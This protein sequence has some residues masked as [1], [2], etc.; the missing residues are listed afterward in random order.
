MGG[1]GASP[2][3]PLHAGTSIWFALTQA[4]T[5][6]ALSKERARLSFVSGG[7][8]CVFTYSPI[9]WGS[10][11]LSASS[12]AMS[13]EKRGWDTDVPFR[14]ERPT[15]SQSLYLSQLGS[16]CILRKGTDSI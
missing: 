12:S 6:S 5:T 3:Y 4:T 11:A 10:D 1:G 15:A 8:P 13:L 9:A 2:A 16:P 7:P 14:A